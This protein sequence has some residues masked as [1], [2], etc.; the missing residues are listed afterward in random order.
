MKGR[1]VTYDP[2][3]HIVQITKNRISRRL[4]RMLIIKV[5]WDSYVDVHNKKMG[6]GILVRESQGDVLAL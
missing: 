4:L 1:F 2:N 3:N 5:N 6:L